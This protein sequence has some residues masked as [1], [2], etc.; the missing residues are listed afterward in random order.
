MSV[1]P[2]P[3]EAPSSFFARES[4]P[5]MLPS[6]IVSPVSMRTPPIS[7]GSTPMLSSVSSSLPPAFAT[8]AA[9]AFSMR[10]AAAAMSCSAKATRTFAA[11][12]A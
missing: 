5:A 4:M 12:A 7:A 2:S 3:A 10:C 9:I 6:K 11:P 8:P 1:S